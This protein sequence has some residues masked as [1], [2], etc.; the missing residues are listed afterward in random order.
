MER[1]VFETPLGQIVFSG[2][3]ANGRP[4]LVI[5]RGAYANE[6]Q[7]SQMHRFIKD[8]NIIYGDIPGNMSPF[9]I[10]NTV[11]DFSNAYTVAIECL[12]FPVVVCGNSLGGL[13]ALGI[14]AENVQSIV[15]IEPPLQPL[16]SKA[17]RSAIA[18]KYHRSTDTVEKEFLYNV[19]GASPEGFHARD[20]RS[21]FA[22]LQIRTKVI[23]GSDATFVPSVVLEE[24]ANTMGNHPFINIERVPGVGHAVHRGGSDRIVAAVSAALVSCSY[25]KNVDSTAPARST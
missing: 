22:D 7:F 2:E 24:D 17:L 19:F 12:N 16:K 13:I 10:N 11:S 15:A 20:Y 4:Y 14:R 18:D 9:L 5:I 6:D 8:V 21:I 1:R 25:R 23:I 3:F